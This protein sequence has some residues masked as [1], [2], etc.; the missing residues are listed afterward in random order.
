MALHELFGFLTLETVSELDRGGR[1]TQELLP[2][3]VGNGLVPSL[4]DQDVNDA[5]VGGAPVQKVVRELPEVVGDHGTHRQTVEHLSTDV[6]GRPWFG[7]RARHVLEPTRTLR[8][9]ADDL[10]DVRVVSGEDAQ[11]EFGVCLEDAGHG[12]SPWW[13]GRSAHKEG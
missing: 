2:V 7:V 4:G 9:T 6:L 1:R 5:R 12:V 3:G 11:K 10:P 8:A 13:L